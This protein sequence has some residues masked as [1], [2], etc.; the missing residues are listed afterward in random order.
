MKRVTGLLRRGL[1]PILAVITAFIFGAIVIVLTDLK[2][3]QKIDTDPAGA[4]LGAI[5]GV[6]RGYGALLSGAF[7][8]PGRILTAIQSGNVADITLAIRPGS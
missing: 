5:G 3:W 6:G 4:I 8:D 2:S 7:G 1:V